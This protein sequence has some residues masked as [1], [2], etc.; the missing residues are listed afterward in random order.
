MRFSIKLLFYLS[1]VVPLT[2]PI[3]HIHRAIVL[4][5]LQLMEGAWLKIFWNNDGISTIFPFACD[6]S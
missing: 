5:P 3:K 4:T 1:L 2:Y 6:I